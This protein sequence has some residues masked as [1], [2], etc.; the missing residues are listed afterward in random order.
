MTSGLL[1]DAN[2][3]TDLRPERWMEVAI[4][5][6][7]RYGGVL[8]LQQ[9]DAQQ[10]QISSL[11]RWNTF[12]RQKAEA[13]KISLAARPDQIRVWHRRVIGRGVKK[14]RLGSFHVVEP[15]WKR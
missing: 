3:K 9:F 7:T 1:G 4:R 2:L 10:Q 15:I 6:R 14:Q 11:S 5:G 12:L 13:C 8:A